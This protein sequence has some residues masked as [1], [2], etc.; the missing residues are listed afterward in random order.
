MSDKTGTEVSLGSQLDAPWIEAQIFAGIADN[1]MVKGE[2]GYQHNWPPLG[3]H[4][5]LLCL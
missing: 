1:S 5:K 4:H 3:E 2:T